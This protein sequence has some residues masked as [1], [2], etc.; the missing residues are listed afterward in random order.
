MFDDSRPGPKPKRKTQPFTVDLLTEVP[1]APAHLSDNAKAHWPRCATPLVR[2]GMLAATDIPA[3]CELCAELA[4][5]E[6]MRTRAE[7]DGWTVTHS[8]GCVSKHPV[9]QDIDR[10]G[11]RIAVLFKAMGMTAEGRAALP[12]VDAA[13]VTPQDWLSRNSPKFAPDYVPDV[14]PTTPGRWAHLRPDASGRLPHHEGYIS[15]DELEG[16]FAT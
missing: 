15:P 10:A 1:E 2:A 7:A 12:A 16:D 8:N 13:R 3:L 9:S 6:S 4:A 5:A 11:K 14:T